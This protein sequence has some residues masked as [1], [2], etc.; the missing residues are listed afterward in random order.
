MAKVTMLLSLFCFFIT[1][2]NLAQDT[3]FGIKAGLNYASV[4]G[5]LTEGIKFRFSGHGG[6]YLESE[7]S[8]K[9]AFQID[10][11][12]SSQGFQFSSD[13]QSIENTGIT[14][15]QNDFRTNV[16]LNFLTVP[17]V[18]KFAL[19]DLLAVEF[20]PQFGFLLNQVSKIKNLDQRDDIG[21]QHRTVPDKADPDAFTMKFRNFL[22]QIKPQKPHE[23]RDFLGRAFPV[24]K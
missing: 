24:F 14:L 4:V 12:Y 20:G 23:I 18:G 9:F 6:I 11:L 22:T 2:T 10:L 5:D 16:Q 21:R 17:I 8:D 13:L 7:F 1:S 3:R 15:D 19:N